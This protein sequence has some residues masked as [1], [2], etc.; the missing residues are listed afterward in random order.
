MKTNIIFAGA[1]ALGCVS[2]G[3]AFAK[4]DNTFLKDAVQGDNSEVALGQLA[5]DKGES[6]AVRSFGMMLVSDHGKHKQKAVALAREMKVDAP[7]EMK[8]EAKQEMNKLKGMSGKQ[9]DAEIASYMVDDHKKDIA[10]YK[11]KAADGTGKVSTLA[12]KTIP[13]LQKHLRMAQ[14]LASD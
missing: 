4:D 3:A 10:E 12:K 1:V 14:K 9:F 2:A 11:E 13:T 6:K 8:D 7:D 5:V